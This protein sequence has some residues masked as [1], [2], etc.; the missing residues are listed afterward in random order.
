[1]IGRY[2]CFRKTMSKSSVRVV[3]YSY[4]A[5]TAAATHLVFFCINIR[6]LTYTLLTTPR[7][8]ASASR[9]A[10]TSNQQTTS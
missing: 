3:T 9:R 4:N 7:G 1:M 6:S 5:A 2:K 8:Q 10:A